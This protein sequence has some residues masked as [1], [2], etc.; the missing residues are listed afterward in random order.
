MK[1]KQVGNPGSAVLEFSVVQGSI[2]RTCCVFGASCHVIQRVQRAQ[3][4]KHPRNRS[5]KSKQRW[6]CCELSWSWP[7]L[8]APE[9]MRRSDVWNGSSLERRALPSHPSHPSR[10]A[11][12][13]PG[14]NSA[15]HCRRCLGAHAEGPQPQ[16]RWCWVAGPTPRNF[17]CW[18]SHVVV[19]G[20]AWC[21][22]LSDLCAVRPHTH[23]ASGVR[24]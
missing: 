15:A 4:T 2:T 18:Q 1:G 19:G 3:R 22:G 21:S 17:R 6:Q 8:N 20:N 24:G 10:Q 14:P 16:N 9:Q 23:G 12:R 7:G 11:Q 13:L 5:R